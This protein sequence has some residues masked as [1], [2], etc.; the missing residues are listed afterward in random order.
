MGVCSDCRTP[1]CHQ[2]SGM[3]GAQLLCEV[4]LLAFHAKEQAAFTHREDAVEHLWDAAVEAFLRAMAVAGN[5]GATAR[6]HIKVGR[7]TFSRK[8]FRVPRRVPGWA[9]GND[10]SSTVVLC[11][12]G[13]LFFTP[14]FANWNHVSKRAGPDEK[15]RT[16]QPPVGWWF[17]SRAAYTAN[18]PG[19]T[20]ADLLAHHGVPVPAEVLAVI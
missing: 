2:H 1:V 10:N 12:D 6:Y 3:G 20:L 11:P 18:A 9:V 19:S 17:K 5:P 16:A 7:T 15:A 4:H 14:T 8:G 13:S